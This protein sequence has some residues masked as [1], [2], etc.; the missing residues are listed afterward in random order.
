MRIFKCLAF[1]LVLTLWSSAAF[2]QYAALEGDSRVGPWLGLGGI[3]FNG[4]DTAGNSDSDV[5][6]T[7]NF[8]GVTEY[9]AWQLFYGMNDDSS[10]LGGSLDYI[11]ADN[12]EDCMYPDDG[13]WWFGAGV[14]VA[15][16][17]DLYFDNANPGNAVDEVLFGGNLGLGYAW[18]QWALQFYGHL[19]TDSHFAFQGMVL[20]SLGGD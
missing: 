18:D 7:I 14:S 8:A 10:A 16:V 9:L 5:L 17:S 11:L 19:F 12:F 4:D 3:Y 15:S 2:A 20:Y 13:I 6:P 1:A